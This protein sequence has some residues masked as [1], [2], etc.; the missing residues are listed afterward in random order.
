MVEFYQKRLNLCAI[1]G[2]LGEIDIEKFKYS[3]N[4]MNHRGNDFQNII[5]TPFGVFG[6]N[7][8]A[9]EKI[10]KNLQPLFKNNIFVFDNRQVIEFQK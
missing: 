6:F 5:K 3:L 1:L 7:R 9:I 8:L 2:I 4:L 10:S